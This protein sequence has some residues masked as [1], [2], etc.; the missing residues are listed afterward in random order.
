LKFGNGRLEKEALNMARQKATAIS[1][2]KCLIVERHEWETRARQ[3]QLQFVLETAQQFFGPGN[4]ERTIEVRVFLTPPAAKP[5]FTRQITIS[6]KYSDATCRT[7][8]FPE[9]G[10]FPSSCFCFLRRN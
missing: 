2:R 7:N 4:A 9:M 5:T 10:S 6:R 1:G 8:K 3:Q